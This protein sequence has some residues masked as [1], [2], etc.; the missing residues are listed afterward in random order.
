MLTKTM[1][2]ALLASALVLAG[3]A[4]KRK[5]TDLPPPPPAASEAPTGTAAEPAPV[6]SGT[7]PGSQED[8]IARAGSDRV[9]FGFDSHEVD[10]EARE[11]LTRQA[12]WLR[13][14]PSVRVTIEGH[15]D[16]RGTREYNLALGDRRATSVKNALAA[17]GVPASRMSTISYGKERP[18]VAGSDE[19]AY[20]QN[21]RAV[22]MV[23]R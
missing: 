22:T 15:A 9:F 11:T 17:L 23:I 21:R 6:T 16:E 10:G 1:T 5:T 12:A 7:V 13:D 2:A 4:G 20:A 14:N 8:L 19:E 3:C 18:A